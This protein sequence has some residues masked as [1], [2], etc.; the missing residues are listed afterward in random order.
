MQCVISFHKLKFPCAGPSTP[1]FY[2]ERAA[3][4]S[5]RKQAKS[6]STSINRAIMVQP[7]RKAPFFLFSVFL[8][9][10]DQL[11]K[12]AVTEHVIRPRVEGAGAPMN[13]ADWYLAA[14]APLPFAAMEILPFFNLVMVWNRGIS[15]GLL[16]HS[17]DYGP[18]MLVV[19]ALAI[20]LVFTVLLWRSHE[21]IPATGMA[22]IIGGALGN[23]IDRLRFNAVI[24]F[25]DFHANGYHWPAF[26]VADS[27]IFLGVATLIIASLF[28][29]KSTLAKG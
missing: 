8:I 29:G 19:L 10:A 23:V 2:K 6:C 26:N 24:D 14:P 3:C 22:L 16:N 4:A 9:L 1:L 17:T 12:W 5:I 27:C 21:K 15:F 13:V 7:M 18:L 11:S 25:L 28:P 20:T